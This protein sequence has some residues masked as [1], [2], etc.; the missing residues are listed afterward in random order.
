MPARKCLRRAACALAV[1]AS[2][3]LAQDRAGESPQETFD[4]AMQERARGDLHEAIRSF[5]TLL[6]RNPALS[7]AR[8]ELAVAYY[9]ALDHRAALEQARLVLA[10]PA[11]PPAVRANLQRLIAQIEA[12]AEPHRFGGNASIGWLYDTNVSAGPSSPSYEAG[13]GVVAVDPNAAKRADSGLMITLGGSHRWLSPMRPGIGGRDGALLWQSQALFNR[14]SYRHEN[15]Y[16]L[17]VITLSTGPAWISPP[18][19]RAALPLQF[20]RLDLG[21]DHY[22]DILGTSPS[23]VFGGPAG[24]ELQVDALLQKRAYRRAGEEGR[25]SRFQS[26]GLQAGRVI[27][28][29]TVQGGLRYNRDDAEDARW[30]YRGHE[31][32]VL[33][34]GTFASRGSAYVRYTRMRLGYDQPDPVAA[35]GRTD[36]E[37]RWSLGAAWR[38]GGTVESPWSLNI[39]LLDVDHG[40]TVPF[41][42]FDRQQWSLTLSAAF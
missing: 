29:L 33:L 16:D 9:H 13:G 2:C 5:Q 40:S 21:Y 1:F 30:D 15:D 35:T 8:L 36:R 20:D 32:F 27:A 3:A 41:Y 28:E 14:V 19:L 4:R 31:W 39:G 18:R 17:Q 26:L 24:T 10:D 23:V 37:T 42:A 7:R 22:L 38:V 11:T 25:D 34:A 6:S 12:D